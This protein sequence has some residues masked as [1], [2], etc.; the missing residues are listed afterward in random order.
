[1]I[2]K[3]ITVIWLSLV[4]L[5]IILTEILPNRGFEA[6]IG[7]VNQSL[8]VLIALVSFYIFKNEPNAKNKPIFLNFTVLFAGAMLSF[9]QLFVGKAFLSDFPF[10]S[11]YFYQYV[12]TGFFSFCLGL[13][14]LYVVIDTL[15]NDIRTFSKY[16]ITLLI[17]GSV[18]AYYYYPILENPKYLYTTEDILDFKA[19]A[20]ASDQLAN[21]GV[22]NPTAEDVAAIVQLPAWK[23]GKE[24]GVLFQAEKVKRV[25]ELLPY[26]EGSNYLSLLYKPVHLNVIYMNVLCI[27]FIFLFFG[28]QYKNDPP[29]GAY[30]EKII[31]LFLPFC[32]L[33]IVHFFGYIMSVE[34][35]TYLDYY[36]VGQ[37]ASLLNLVALL[38][39]FSLRL[40]FITS[41]KGEF[42]ERELVSDSEHISRWRDGLDN[43]LVR[44]FLNPQTFHGRLFA[45]RAPREKT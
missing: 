37:Y 1:M 40:R 45:P 43:L 4:L 3:K 6:T 7:G 41:V 5:A 25:A 17:V 11:F 30:I 16:A 18:F 29:Q 39:F 24:V 15:F 13:A 27:I 42:Y 20:A 9:I 36:R 32:S 21:Q 2:A 23:D 10:V 28:Y 34:H 35:A 31:F 19:V 8:M 33:E 22:T 12:T 38:I 14:V 26:L 44:H